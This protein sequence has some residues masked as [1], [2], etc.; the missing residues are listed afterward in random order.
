MPKAVPGLVAFNA[1]EWSESLYGRTDIENY[2]NACRKIRNMTLRVQGPAR[3][4]GGT[5]FVYPIKD[6]S[7]RSWLVRFE[8]NVEQSYLM[9]FGDKYI[10]FYSNHG[11]VMDP[12]NPTDPLEV[13]TPYAIADLTRSDGTFALRFRQFND[14]I[15]IFHRN[16]EPQKLSRTGA[17]AFSLSA[18]R[19]KG[20]PFKD[21]DPDNNIIVYIDVGD[22]G[23]GRNLT[24][25]S[26]IFKAGHIGGLFLLEQ[27]TTDDIAQWE[28]GKS[29]T[30]GDVRRSDGKNYTAL[31]TATSGTVAPIHTVGAKYDGDAGVQWQFN[32]AGYGWVRITNVGGGGLTAVCEVLSRVPDEAVGPTNGSTRWAFGAWSGE[33]GWPDCVTFYRERLILARDLEV[34]GTVAG[35]FDDMRARDEGGL[36][37]TDM[38]IRRSIVSD[39][40]NRIEWLASSDQAVIIGTAGDEHTLSAATNTEPFGAEN[41][42]T[43]VQTDYGSRH[44]EPERIGDS[45]F[46]VQRAGRELRD[47]RLIESSVDEKWDSTDATVYADHVTKSGVIQMAFQQKPDPILWCMR[48]DGQLAGLTVNREQQVRGWHPHRIGGYSDANGTQ[49]AVVESIAAIFAPDGTRNETWMIVRRYI[50]GQTRRYIE[51][52]DKAFDS[53]DGDDPEDAFFVDCGL[54]YDGKVAAT[55]TPGVG[56]DVDGTTDVVFDASAPVFSAGDVGRF[57]HY[58]YSRIDV[59]GKT[60]WYKSVAEITEYVS[61]QQV[62][63]TIES[64]W[65]NLD[66]IAVDGWRMTVTSISGLDHLEGQTIQL[67]VDGAAHDDKVVTGG[68]VTLDNPGSKI[69]GGLAANAVL[70]PMPPEAGAADGTAQ[71]K[72]KRAHR[73]G[74]RFIDS[75]G[76]RYG[77][78]EDSEDLDEILTRDSEDETDTAP[79]LFTGIKV[80]SWPDGYTDDMLLTIVQDQPLPLTVAGLIPHMKTE[81]SR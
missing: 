55:L 28:A 81:D 42:R 74:I 61:D 6:E 36:V 33:Y 63:C 80:V 22:V 14:V 16:Y 76:A 4:R 37:T 48:A 56:A 3:R 26:A 47:M 44:V 50:N 18:Y 38:A 79:P 1:G 34:W 51:Y 46:F 58:R 67:C 19:P 54:T 30:I 40:C 60:N 31:N 62:L 17:S 70:Q 75:L 68:S 69:H 29:I 59:K 43:K 12:L 49:F 27:S 5:R 10:R 9:E 7:T 32:D 20:G 11:R 8:F 71:S 64:P 15:Y 65:P 21:L 41:V 72:T 57:I 52:M 39:R 35:D 66:V 13:A 23:V 73:V 53:N 2:K 45:V 78:D 77:R 24:A 25:S